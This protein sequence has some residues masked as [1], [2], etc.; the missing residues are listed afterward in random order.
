MVPTWE[1]SPAAI[2]EVTSKGKSKEKELE[3]R[4]A[5][6]KPASQKSEKKKAKVP[7]PEVED[8]EE[9]EEST[10][11]DN[12]KSDKE[13]LPSTLLPD[14]KTRRSMNTQSSD[15]K[16]PRPIYRSPFAPKC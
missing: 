3:S 12:N 11:E 10:A 8:L 16:K 9:G 14:Q 7:S 6:S 4:A 15:R 2:P 5:S 1:V 13:E